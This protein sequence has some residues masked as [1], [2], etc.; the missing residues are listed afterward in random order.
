[1]NSPGPSTTP[2]NDAVLSPYAR[3][4]SRS[5]LKY[6]RGNPASNGSTSSPFVSPKLEASQPGSTDTA[7]GGNEG[8]VW[9][10]VGSARATR[11]Q[12]VG[13]G[14]V[15]DIPR[16]KAYGRR[17]KEQ[18][19]DSSGSGVGKVDEEEGDLSPRSAA[20]EGAGEGLL[21]ARWMAKQQRRRPATIVSFHSLGGSG[22]GD[23]KGG[24]PEQDAALVEEIARNRV[25]IASYGLSYTA[26][27]IINR[28]LADDPGTEGRLAGIMQGGGLDALQFCVCRP[29]TAQQFQVFLTDLG[30]KLFAKATVYY[31]D[32][33]MRTQTKLAAIPQLP[34]SSRPDMPGSVY[35]Y[36]V[37][38]E[39]AAGASADMPSSPAAA[40]AG[41]PTS[42]QSMSAI[43]A[44]PVLISR[45]SRHL[46][47]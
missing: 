37:H 30:R 3:Q 29:G 21:S 47:L 40:G 24:R 32:A 44:D 10:A 26:V 23:D 33:F 5:I 6:L 41:S 12:A 42:A 15:D 7:G 45:F 25:C 14:R 34:V 43:L 18:L 31:A 28:A 20:G 2:T 22:N 16:R 13:F 19:A 39:L 36:G 27:V 8:V 9:D 4:V 46:P 38:R 17:G 35:Q 11:W 1:L